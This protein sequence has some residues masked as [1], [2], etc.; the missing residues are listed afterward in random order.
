MIPKKIHYVWL[1]N[2]EK[3]DLV[4]NCIASWKK[5]LPEYTVIEWNE[6]NSPCDNPVVAYC[7]QEKRFA[8]ASDYIR[9]FALYNFG[10]IYLDTD[11]EVLA[12]FPEKMLTYDFFAGYEEISNYINGAVIGA[13]KESSYIL[14]LLN[15]ISNRVFIEPIGKVMNANLNFLKAST[16]NYL[17]TQNSVFYPKNLHGKIKI[18]NATLAIHH[19]EN[20][21]GTGSNTFFHSYFKVFCKHLGIKQE[22]INLLWLIIDD[23]TYK[24]ETILRVHNTLKDITTNKYLS[25]N[26]EHKLNQ[27]ISSYVGQNY[28]SPSRFTPWTFITALTDSIFK[29]HAA[30]R[31][32]FILLIKPILFYK[33][34][35]AKS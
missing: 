16:Q 30:P 11:M 19:W 28:I 20:S 21:W 32:Y 9:L 3:P 13:C 8:F 7:I 29:E 4:K 18:T 12:P 5:Y 23:T 6:T 35:K 10:G 25:L 2:Q 24:K 31:M 34:V 33:P 1:G 27:L 14:H 15:Y 17:I 26:I 22:A